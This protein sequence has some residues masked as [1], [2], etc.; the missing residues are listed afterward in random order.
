MSSAMPNVMPIAA[1]S[2]AP[3]RRADAAKRMRVSIKTLRHYE[4]RGLINP[5]RTRVGWRLYERKDLERIEQILAFKAMG[6]GLAQIASL[7]DASPDVVAAALAAQEVHLEGQ[8][9]Q[10]AEALDA[11]RDAR[12]RHGD[13]SLLAQAA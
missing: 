10:I 5:P 2:T 9:K 4:K 7:L 12:A 1:P 3:L 8:A 11:V 13:R 6:F